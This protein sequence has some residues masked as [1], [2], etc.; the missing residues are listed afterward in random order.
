MSSRIKK[1]DSL[2]YFSTRPRGAQISAH[3]SKQSLEIPNRDFLEKNVIEIT[4]KLKNKDIEMPDYWG[5]Y[6]ILPERFEFWQGR[7]DRLHDRIE[8]N[9]IDETKWSKRRLAP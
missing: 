5:G 3:A 2:K 1:D 9:K 6:R 7:Q 4:K 8:Y